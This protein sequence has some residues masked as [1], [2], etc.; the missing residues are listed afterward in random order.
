MIKIILIKINK[1]RFLTNFNSKLVNF[2]G[3]LCHSKKKNKK[4]VK[5]I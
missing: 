2:K 5:V 4:I 3:G 1:Y